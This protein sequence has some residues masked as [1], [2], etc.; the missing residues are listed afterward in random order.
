MSNSSC[1]G[2][3][4]YMLKRKLTSRENPLTLNYEQT[5]LRQQRTNQRVSMKIVTIIRRRFFCNDLVTELCPKWA[6]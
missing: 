1:S 3:L 2:W 4:C 5:E 6:V